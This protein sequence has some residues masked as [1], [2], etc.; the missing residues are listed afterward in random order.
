MTPPAASVSA[1]TLPE[2]NVPGASLE[3]KELEGQVLLFVN[4]ASF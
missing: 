3:L 1:F 4:V 2:L